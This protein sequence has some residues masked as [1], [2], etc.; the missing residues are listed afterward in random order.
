MIISL[1]I[2]IQS[3]LW[4]LQIEKRLDKCLCKCTTVANIYLKDILWIWRLFCLL[5]CGGKCT[6]LLQQLN[7]AK[8]QSSRRKICQKQGSFQLNKR[9]YSLY[10]KKSGGGFRRF[11]RML[12]CMQ[13][14]QQ[15]SDSVFWKKQ[16]PEWTGDQISNG[17]KET[18]IA[19]QQTEIQQTKTRLLITVILFLVLFFGALL[20]Y[21]F[22]KQR[23]K[24]CK[25]KSLRLNNRRN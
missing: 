25:I 21:L 2:C 23:Q 16:H 24:Y 1:R 14:Y 11:Q 22:L 5:Q 18:Q 7:E 12:L 15:N 20:V 9:V 4:I 17:K 6:F 13:P 19:Q 10:T 8:R 3:L